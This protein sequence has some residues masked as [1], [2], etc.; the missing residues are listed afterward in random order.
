MA[1]GKFVD[2][3]I[4]ISSSRKHRREKKGFL[5]NI[6][7]NSRQEKKKKGEKSESKET[8]KL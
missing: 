6:L 4:R 8:K 2:L 7:M 1:D 5:S 3:M